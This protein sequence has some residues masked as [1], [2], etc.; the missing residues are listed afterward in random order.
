MPPPQH[1]FSVL[2]DVSGSWGCGAISSTQEWFQWQ[3][4]KADQISN[5][6]IQEMIPVVISAA[7]WGNTWQGNR[8]L[9]LSDNESVV[10][11][12]NARSARDTRLVHL[13]CRLFFYA[14]TYQFTLTAEHIAGCSS[15][16]SLSQQCI[17]CFYPCSSGAT[18]TISYTPGYSQSPLGAASRVDIASLETTVQR[19]YCG[20]IARSTTRTYD[21]AKRRRF[22]L[23]CVT[24]GMEQ[25]CIYISHLA[26]QEIHPHVFVGNKAPLH[27]P[28]SS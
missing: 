15:R 7:I 13:S 16:C 27:I 8:V 2:S 11:V 1:S 28:R 12:L 24:F 18:D 17:C 10:S 3:W 26:S 9:I 23:F 21:S 19:F 25:L 5:I 22:L 6:A 20:G 14:A 4:P